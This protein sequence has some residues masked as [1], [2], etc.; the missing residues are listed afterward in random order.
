MHTMH[1]CTAFTAQ[2][3]PCMASLASP[4]QVNP[5]RLQVVPDSLQDAFYKLTDPRTQMKVC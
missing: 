5:D 4:V 3:V 1:V 2:S